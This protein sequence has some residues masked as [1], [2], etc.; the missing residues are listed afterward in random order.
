MT[1]NGTVYCYDKTMSMKFTGGGL[2]TGKFI[3][4]GTGH[5]TAFYGAPCKIPPTPSATSQRSPK[6]EQSSS[7]RTLRVAQ[8]RNLTIS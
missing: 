1:N 2:F 5:S 6:Q 7:Y 8:L 4:N 3:D